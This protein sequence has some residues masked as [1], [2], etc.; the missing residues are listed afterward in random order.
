L[1]RR[2]WRRHIFEM[3]PDK[4][5][6]GGT[7]QRKARGGFFGLKWHVYMYEDAHLL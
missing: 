1:E 5:E 6:E 7:R 4:M 2:G 3:F